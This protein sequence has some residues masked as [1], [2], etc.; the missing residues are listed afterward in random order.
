MF[1]PKQFRTLVIVL[2]YSIYQHLP[3]SQSVML[4]AGTLVFEAIL[5][6]FKEKNRGRDAHRIPA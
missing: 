2:L 4:Y 3:V 5:T 6:Y 1:P